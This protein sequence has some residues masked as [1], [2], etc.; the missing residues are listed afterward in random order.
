MPSALLLG[1]EVPLFG[2]RPGVAWSAW[3]DDTT[4]TLRGSIWLKGKH[5]TTE[6]THSKLEVARE[7]CSLPFFLSN[8]V[9]EMDHNLNQQI[10]VEEPRF[11]PRGFVAPGTVRF[12]PA[13]EDRKSIDPPSEQKMPS[14]IASFMPALDSYRDIIK[15]QLNSS[16]LTVKA[17]ADGHAYPKPEEVPP[18]ADFTTH[19]VYITAEQ[20]RAI[21][22]ATI[23]RKQ[24]TAILA[25]TL[26]PEIILSK[27]DV[28]CFDHDY[29]YEIVRIEG[30]SLLVRRLKGN[31]SGP[32]GEIVH[33][34][35]QT[36]V[37][38]I[39]K[40]RAEVVVD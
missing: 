12:T 40:G 4:F 26:L 11:I 34:S 36:Y 30:A 37:S 9:S 10:S 27:G 14:P 17:V 24:A 39:R 19:T 20:E 33:D 22:D 13:A 15:E 16:F 23:T 31:S 25:E 2:T 35:V 18:M 1:V 7:K 28:V 6:R 3:Q 32:A 5:F 29:C 8:L 21:R 38:A